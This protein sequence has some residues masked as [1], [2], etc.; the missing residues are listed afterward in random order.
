MGPI[1]PVGL[2]SGVKLPVAIA[3]TELAWMGDQEQPSEAVS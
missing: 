1:Q 3:E 2:T